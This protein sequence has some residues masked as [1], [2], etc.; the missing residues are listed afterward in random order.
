MVAIDEAHLLFEWAEFRLVYIMLRNLRFVL[1]RYVHWFACTA[2][3]SEE[4]LTKIMKH[5]GFRYATNHNH[6]GYV[7][8]V[9]RYSVD[10]PEI[11]L[12]V[13][14]IQRG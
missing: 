12:G 7:V 6:N 9:R 8:D 4:T 3:A 11:D 5:G 2:T 10:R 1:L 14:P 13:F